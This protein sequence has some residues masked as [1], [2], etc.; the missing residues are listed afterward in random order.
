MAPFRDP[1]RRGLLSASAALGL[2]SVLPSCGGARRALEGGFRDGEHALGHGLRDGT[3][4]GEP[5]R[6]ERARVVVVGGGAA[7]ASAAWR[8][9]RAGEDD[10]AVLE[11]GATLG[12]TAR[13]GEMAGVPHPWGAHYLPVPHRGQRALCAFLEEAGV[14]SGYDADGRLRVPPEQLVR[15][16]QERLWS[17]GS[18]EEGIWP[19]VGAQA[20]DLQQ[21][22][23]FEAL[24]DELNAPDADG[25][26]AFELPLTAANTRHRE[27]DAVSA[28]DWAASHGL[29]SRR[30]RYYLEYASRDDYGSHL[31]DCSAWALVHYFC[32][33]TLPGASNSAEFMTWPEGNQR[34]VDLLTVD[35]GERVRAQQV[36]LR[37]TPSD[38]G[39]VE[40]LV[41]DEPAQELVRWRC[42]RAILATPQFVNKHLI[43]RDPAHLA[44][45]RFRYSS[46]VVANLHLERRPLERGF[47]PAWDSVI[48]ESDSLGYVDATWQ[49]D[50]AARDLVWTWYLP[51]CASDERT[52]R[53]ELYESTWEQWSAR[54]LD[55]LRRPHPDI[56]DCVTRVDVWRWGHGM[57]RPTPGFVWGPERAKAAQPFGG[58]HFG[59]SDLG[60]LPLFE[61]AQHTGVRAAEEVLTSLGHEF[62]SLLV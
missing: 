19:S 38:S 58:L 15:G 59:H 51:L 6:E 61:V 43:P 28:A 9:L 39:D 8:L 57:I 62:E 4:S 54:V 12:G 23:R 20:E 16:P 40:L 48:F 29:D 45:L 53:G 24:L 2:S 47:Q 14:G 33:R 35:L 1:T 55:D 49:L 18:F 44:R 21:L 32:A 27:L 25:Q 30:M 7:G 60:G 50:R 31:E 41:W 22:T 37:A 13:G 26:R 46:W 17:W 5:A 36:V 34:L 56:D 52:A 11:L 42:E 3:F 10:L